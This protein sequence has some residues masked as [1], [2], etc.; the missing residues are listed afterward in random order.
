MAAVEYQKPQVYK[1]VWKFKDGVH[2]LD[3]ARRPGQANGVVTQ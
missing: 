3:N 1:W 2:S